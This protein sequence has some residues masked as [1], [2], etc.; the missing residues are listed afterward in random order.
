M[1]LKW[2]DVTFPTSIEK[3]EIGP[4]F[5]KNKWLNK[6]SIHS[7]LRDYLLQY[8]IELSSLEQFSRPSLREVGLLILLVLGRLGF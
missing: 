7:L 6:M 8:L 1:S 5:W 4:L 3:L 2:L